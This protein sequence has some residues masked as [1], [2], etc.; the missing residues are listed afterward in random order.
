MSQN[1]PTFRGLLR[2]AICNRTQAQ[3]ANESGISSEHLNRLLNKETINRPTKSTLTKIASAAK[4]NI[5]YQIL[6]D[7]LDKE[8]PECKDKPAADANENPFIPKTFEER[9]HE[10]MQQLVKAI[11]NTDLEHFYVED[12][13]ADAMEHLLQKMETTPGTLSISY[14]LDEPR[15]YIGSQHKDENIPSYIDVSLSMADFQKSAESQLLFYFTK[16]SDKYVIQNISTKVIDISDLFGLPPAALQ[17]ITD[18]TKDEDI[19]E[20]EFEACYNLD[21]YLDIYENPRFIEKY[22]DSD[23]K[24]KE[25][26]VLSHLF[27]KKPVSYPTTFIGSGFWLKE[28][29][30]NFVTFVKKHKA[31]ILAEYEDSIELYQ[32]LDTQ[33]DKAETAEELIKIFDTFYESGYMDANSFETGWQAAIANVMSAETNWPFGSHIHRTDERYEDRS[34]HDCILLNQSDIDEIGIRRETL[35][36]TLCT[37]AKQL[38]IKEFGDLL[39]HTMKETP[40]FYKPMMYKVK[41]TKPKVKPEYTET[42]TEFTPWDSDNKPNENGQYLV[43]LKDGRIFPCIYLKKQNLWLRFHKEWS[44]LIEAYAPMP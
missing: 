23:A 5:T 25:E 14:D 31:H 30:P 12:S 43:R 10:T 40:L 35:L 28:V 41:E 13:I 37:Y 21:Y 19:S 24:T 32:D 15:P 11:E 22:M 16:V 8:D 18:K 6:Q 42:P 38:G 1:F 29:P 33:M 36:N 27:G 3:F 2:D 9:A 17:M 26:R 44:Y 4:N 39:F 20:E 34:K 7:A